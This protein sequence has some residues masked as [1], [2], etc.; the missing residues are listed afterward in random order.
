L[1]CPFCLETSKLKNFVIGRGFKTTKTK[2]DFTLAECPHCKNRMWWKT[3]ITMLKW[4]AKEYAEFVFGYRHSG[5]W[6]K[7]PDF[8]KWKIR[9]FKIGF[10]YSFWLRYNELNGTQE[11]NENED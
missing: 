9:L 7:I 3:L 6:K 1:I 10:S 2:L 4:N 11:E 8:N 5:F